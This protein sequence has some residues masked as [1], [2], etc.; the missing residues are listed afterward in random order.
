MQIEGFLRIIRGS[1]SHGT[2]H[3]PNTQQAAQQV[4]SNGATSRAAPT[5]TSDAGTP[6]QRETVKKILAAKGDF[7]HVLGV[8]RTADEDEIKKAYRKLALKL[9]PD[10]CRAPGA[11]E[12]FKGVF[13]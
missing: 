7:Y 9:H 2:S 10:K 6:A 13:F 5:A 11:E 4:P 3:Q 1:S 12:A 8:G